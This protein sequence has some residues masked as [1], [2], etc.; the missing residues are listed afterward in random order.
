LGFARPSQDK[1]RPVDLNAVVHDALRLCHH[2]LGKGKLEVK[3][4]LGPG[5]PPL[6]GVEAELQQVFINLFTNAAQAMPPA[7]GTLPVKTELVEDG[8]RVTLRDDGTG[9]PAENLPR[10][11]EPFF[12]TKEERGT[13]LGLSIV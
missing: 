11:F 8:V 7:G 4:E 13:G 2:D 3:S 9:I 10:I 12:S 5:L 6:V 1:E